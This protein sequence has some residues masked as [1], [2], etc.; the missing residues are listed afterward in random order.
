MARRLISGSRTRLG[1]FSRN[2]L[3]IRPLPCRGVAIQARLPVCSRTWRAKT[4]GATAHRGAIVA[5]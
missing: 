2:N 5:A 4:S 1:R 3:V